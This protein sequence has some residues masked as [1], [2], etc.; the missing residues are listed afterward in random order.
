MTSLTVEERKDGRM[1]VIGDAGVVVEHQV[2]MFETVL[3]FKSRDL[4]Q[5]RYKLR[6]VLG[7]V[8]VL[9]FL[10]P[11]VE[12]GWV[13]MVDERKGSRRTIF[14]GG[15]VGSQFVH[16]RHRSIEVDLRRRHIGNQGM[17]A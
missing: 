13:N 15:Q 1:E 17:N 12:T 10:T 16:Q 6:R 3:F 9:L 14:C 2:I 8:A 11:G 4:I 5:K 7:A